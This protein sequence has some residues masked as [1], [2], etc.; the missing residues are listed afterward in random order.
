MEGSEM[1]GSMVACAHCHCNIHPACRFCPACGQ[2]TGS[3]VQNPNFKGAQVTTYPMAGSSAPGVTVQGNPAHAHTGGFAQVF[4]LDPRIALLTVVVDTMLFGGQ[5]ATL[6]AST[7]VSVP[8]GIVLGLIT[9]R[10]QRHW[11]GDDRESAMI[12]AFMVGLL[13]A[14]PTSLPGFLTIPSGIIGLFH[15]LPWKRKESPLTIERRVGN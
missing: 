8:A 15:M 11:Y 13:T 12:K 14:I 1:E 3:T 6:G 9:Y 7:M 2:P 10:A 4:G 5:L